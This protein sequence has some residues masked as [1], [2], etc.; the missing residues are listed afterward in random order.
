MSGRVKD[1]EKGAYLSERQRRRTGDQ[2]HA[3]YDEHRAMKRSVSG[4]R[5]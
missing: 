5:G 4:G 1:G 2:Q 3:R